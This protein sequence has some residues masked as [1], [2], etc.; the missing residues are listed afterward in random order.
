MSKPDKSKTCGMG[1]N[2]DEAGSEY[3]IN[4]KEPRLQDY[5]KNGHRAAMQL[6]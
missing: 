1:I 4:I 6:S 2:I 3:L 5:G